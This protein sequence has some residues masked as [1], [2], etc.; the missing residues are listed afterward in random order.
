MSVNEH[1]IKQNVDIAKHVELLRKQAA[2]DKT[3]YIS[4]TNQSLE[5]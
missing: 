2:R 4:G 5:I 3:E 1:L